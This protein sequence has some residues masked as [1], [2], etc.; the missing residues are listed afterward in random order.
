MRTIRIAEGR[1]TVRV[2]DHHATVRV[3]GQYLG[4]L[5]KVRGRWVAPTGDTYDAPA[6][7]AEDLAA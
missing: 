6:A 1:G 7:A 5:T 2:T 3:D 4:R